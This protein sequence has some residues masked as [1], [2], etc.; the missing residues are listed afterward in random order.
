V[1]QRTALPASSFVF[2]VQL[3]GRK[4]LR[5]LPNCIF[6]QGPEMPGCPSDGDARDPPP[7]WSQLTDWYAECRL[8]HTHSHRMLCTPVGFN[9]RSVVF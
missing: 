6:Q 3:T 7:H 4:A 5:P 8:N 1:K 2:Q 9:P